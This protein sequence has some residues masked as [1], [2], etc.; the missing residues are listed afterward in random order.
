MSSLSSH[1]ENLVC[2]KIINYPVQ[3]DLFESKAESEMQ[4][5]TRMVTEIKD[6]TGKVRRKL[7]ADQGALKKRML[8]LENRLEAIEKGLCYGK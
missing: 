8:E 2:A 3:Y 4:A 1:N 6:S 7:F 5:L